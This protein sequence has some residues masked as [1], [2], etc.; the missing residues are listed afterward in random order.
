MKKRKFESNLAPGMGEVQNMTFKDLRRTCVVRGMPFENVLN[1]T[2]P[3]LNK[4][5]LYNYH[6]PIDNTLLDKYDDYVDKLINAKP[7]EDNDYLT[8]PS[9]RLGYVGEKDEEG[10][11]VKTKRIKGM[12]KRKKKV[13]REKT[14][15]GIFKGTKKALTFDLALRGISKE[16]TLK[17][18]LKAFPDAKEK[19][20]GIWY[21]KA[22]KTIKSEK[23][24]K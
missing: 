10:N 20:I 12:P 14:S 9:L 15:Q 21:N 13:K 11:I 23:P 19:S 6:K 16:K 5:F 24:K 7:T 2:F 3:E 22:L 1:G 17:E 4:W 18:V 8:H